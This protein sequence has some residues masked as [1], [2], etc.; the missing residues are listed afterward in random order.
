MPMLKTWNT[1]VLALSLL[2]CPLAPAQT[3]PSEPL[4]APEALQQDFRFLRGEIDR[5]HPEPGLF[6]SRETLRK[7]YDR[8]E[9]QLRQPLS[10]DQAWRALATLNP[11]FADGHMF[12]I[13]PDWKALTRTHLEQGGLLFPY[14]VQVTTSGEITIRAELDGSASA[15]AGMRIEQIN[16]MPA[17]RVA[18]ELLPLMAGETPGLRANLLSRRMWLY[19]WR[20]FGAPREFDLV[21]ARPGGPA[22]LRVAGSAKPPVSLETDGPAGFRKTFAFELLPGNAALLTINQFVWPDQKEFNAFTRDA[23]TKIRDAKVTTLIIDVRENTG[24]NDDMWKEGLVPYIADKPFRNASSYL[25]KVVAGRAS[26]LEKVGDVVPGFGDTWVEPDLNNPLHFSGRTYV[27]VGRLTYSSAVVFSNV[28]QDFGFA[29]LAGAGGYA[30]TRQTGGVQ[31]I[32]LP[33]TGLLIT[34]P[35]FVL[36]RPSG[37]RE[38]ALVHPDIVLPD[39]PFDRMVT[40]NAL[41]DHI[42]GAPWQPPKS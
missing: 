38:P 31:N 34:I 11:L 7:A 36:D 22:H 14:E 16:G 24:G 35:R 4:Y 21:V 37:E 28:V 12:V 10:R 25:K 13:H 17:A 41:L 40:V 8:V 39:S 9:A 5:I 3:A 15:L 27:L 1:V 30:R 20:V 18:H 42:R 2:A 6:T 23:F 32:K 29:Q 19:Y 26:G 33:N